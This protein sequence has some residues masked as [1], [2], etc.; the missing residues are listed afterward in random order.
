MWEEGG[1]EVHV[2]FSPQIATRPGKARLPHGSQHGLSQQGCLGAFLDTQTLEKNP[3]GHPKKF[4][5]QF[6]KNF[7]LKLIIEFLHLLIIPM[8]LLNDIMPYFD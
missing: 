3:S 6:L 1:I 4:C 2:C 7:I 5:V 8:P